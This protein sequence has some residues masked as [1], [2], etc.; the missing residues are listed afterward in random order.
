MQH[1]TYK[2]TTFHIL[3]FSHIPHHTM[4]E[5][6][7]FRIAPYFTYTSHHIS[8]RTIIH[9]KSH[10]GSPFHITPTFHLTSRPHS[11]SH[12]AMHI[13]TFKYKLHITLSHSTHS[14]PQHTSHTAFQPS[15]RITPCLIWRQTIPH[16]SVFHNHISHLASQHTSTSRNTLFH[17][18]I[19]YFKSHHWYRPHYASRHISHCIPFYITFH[20]TPHFRSH[21]ILATLCIAPPHL[22]SLNIDS[23]T[24]FRILHNCIIPPHLTVITPN[25]TSHYHVS[26][27]IPHHTS[28]HHHILHPTTYH[29]SHNTTPTT[30][31]RAVSQPKLYLIP[32]RTTFHIPCHSTHT[33]IKAHIFICRS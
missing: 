13:T 16:H 6:A 33:H 15:F 2:D 17:F 5:I 32:H 21:H 11:I 26:H 19:P 25:S 12:H 10:L 8:H 30:T 4:S 7:T 1:S 14:K 20:I 23:C 31:Y 24:A 18:A 27:N 9:I 29:I 28:V 3:H 22:A